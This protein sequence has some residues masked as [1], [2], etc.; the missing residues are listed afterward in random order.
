MHSIH[1]DGTGDESHTEYSIMVG[2]IQ[3][4]EQ[5][6]RHVVVEEKVLPL[7]SSGTRKNWLRREHF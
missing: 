6:E 5:S 3:F 4:A 2:S 1:K 7:Y